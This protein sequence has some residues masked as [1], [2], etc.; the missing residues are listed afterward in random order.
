MAVPGIPRP[1]IAQLCPPGM[2][3]SPHVPCQRWVL[4]RPVAATHSQDLLQPRTCPLLS[5][6][7]DMGRAVPSASGF[8]TCRES[9][10]LSGLSF[11]ILGLGQWPPLGPCDSGRMTVA[12]RAGG[13]LAGLGQVASVPCLE[14]GHYTRAMPRCRWEERMSS[15]A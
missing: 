2:L 11:I 12:Q 13:E 9:H 5:I 1:G 7:M 6:R 4:L 8:A 10:L 15:C 3:G 14:H